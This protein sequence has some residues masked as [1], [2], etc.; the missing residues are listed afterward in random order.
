MA[1]NFNSIF[2]TVFFFVMIIVASFT[3]QMALSLPFIGDD[4]LV[5]SS[6]VSKNVVRKPIID[7]SSVIG[8]ATKSI[9]KDGKIGGSD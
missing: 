9:P 7:V 2:S 3:P 8:S 1:R 5:D 4:N 6:T